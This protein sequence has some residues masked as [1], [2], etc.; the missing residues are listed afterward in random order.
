[1]WSIK[2][3]ISYDISQIAKEN[4]RD[5]LYSFL[6]HIWISLIHYTKSMW[7]IKPST[8]HYLSQT[9]NCTSIWS[10]GEMLSL[11]HICHP[12]RKVDQT[13]QNITLTLCLS[14]RP[15]CSFAIRSLPFYSICWPNIAIRSLPFTL[16]AD[17]TPS[18]CV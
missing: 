13:L 2:P 6:M 4:S 17:Q 18:S 7:R 3:S 14:S 12:L 5:P 9:A 16:Y 15:G 11:L 1:M 10:M 8:T